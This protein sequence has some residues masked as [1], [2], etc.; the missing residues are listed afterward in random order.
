MPAKKPAPAR[1]SS[2]KPPPAPT[3]AKNPPAK[4]AGKTATGAEVTAALVAT[5]T[6]VSAADRSRAESLLAEIARRK[7]RIAEDFYD[8]GLALSQLFKKKLHLAL[9]HRSFEEM[10]K[11]RDVVSPSTARGLMRLVA[12]MSREQALAV[13]QEKAIALLGYSKA[14]PELDT[15]KTLM[16]SGQLP[17]GKPVAAASVRDLKKATKEVRAAQGKTRP[18]SADA[19]A[20]RAEAKAVSKWLRSCGVSR[21]EVAETRGKEGYLVRVELPVAAWAKL[22]A[23]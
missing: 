16:E 5:A 4:P 22:R 3:A 13:G 8:I 6:K 12:S 11:A 10:L 9:G 21:P 17:G 14:T 18:L 2:A 20:A 19:R 15:P 23:G 1:K 7:E